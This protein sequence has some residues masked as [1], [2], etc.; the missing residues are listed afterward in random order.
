MGVDCPI[1]ETLQIS[2]TCHV[3]YYP[4]SQLN[5]N[6]DSALVDTNDRDAQMA[7]IIDISNYEISVTSL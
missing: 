2:N 1:K 3:L 4:L 5:L 6:I 7:N